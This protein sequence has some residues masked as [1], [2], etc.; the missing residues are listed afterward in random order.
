MKNK[1]KDMLFSMYYFPCC[2]S[3]F[4]YIL[5]L[6]EEEEESTWADVVFPSDEIFKEEDVRMSPEGLTPVSQQ[7]SQT[8][9]LPDAASQH[10][11][12]KRH[13]RLESQRA[14]NKNL[15]KL[16]TATKTENHR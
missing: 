14:R 3:V 15:T 9:T 11:Q 5:E 10:S 6:D 12:M 2:V 1:C 13:Y 4:V 16:R 7:Q 8:L